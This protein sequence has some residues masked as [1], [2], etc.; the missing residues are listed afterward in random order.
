MDPKFLGPKI[1]SDQEFFWTKNFLGQKFFWTKNFFWTVFFFTQIF[2]DP[3]SFWTHI[4]LTK[5]IIDSK[6]V[7]SF[8]AQN[9]FGQMM[10]QLLFIKFWFRN[11]NALE[12][13]VWLW[14][15]PN[16]LI[17]VFHWIQINFIS[18]PYPV[19]KVNALIDFFTHNEHLLIYVYHSI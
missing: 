9:L 3:N 4:F 1:F 5:N 2:L 19:L 10:L 15:R 14:C 18:I 17:Y 8:L 13:G 16:L 7:L 6:F 12:N 11:Q